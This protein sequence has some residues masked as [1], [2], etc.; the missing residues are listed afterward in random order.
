MI[1]LEIHVNTAF[2]IITVPVPNVPAT[3]PFIQDELNSR[4]FIKNLPSKPSSHLFSYFGKNKHF[5]KI[6]SFIVKVDGFQTA[7]L[8]TTFSV[9]TVSAV[10]KVN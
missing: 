7:L 6:F 2:V 10:F 8:N 3:T 9:K 5:R 1:Y 4:E